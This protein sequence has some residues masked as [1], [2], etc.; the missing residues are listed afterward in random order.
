MRP[1]LN[2]ASENST[3]GARRRIPESSLKEVFLKASGDFPAEGERAGVVAEALDFLQCGFEAHYSGDASDEGILVGD[4]DYAWAV[5]TIARLDEPRFVEV[6]GRMIRDG[7][8]RIASGGVVDIAFWTP[9]LGE[10]LSVIS[11]EDV[12]PS[13]ERVRSACRK[14]SG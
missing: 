7:S 10:L 9:H 2:E 8:G 4:N 1:R 13:E 5:E 6:A 11:G 12:K 3:N 14:V